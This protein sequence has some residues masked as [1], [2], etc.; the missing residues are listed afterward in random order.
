M[1]PPVVSVVCVKSVNNR[2][3]KQMRNM[4][5]SA[6]MLAS[7][8][9]VTPSLAADTAIIL[10]NTANPGGAESANGTSSATVLSSN[11]NGI[12]ISASSVQKTTVPADQLTEANLNIDN[13]TGSVET[14]KIIAGANMFPGSASEF[15]L[16]GTIGVTSG[17]ADLVGQY[18]VDNTDTLNGEA[19][20]VTGVGI[21][22]FDSGSLTGPH[23][24][25][26][27][28]TAFDSASG[29]YGL[30]EE[31]TLTLQPGA[32]I[33]VQGVSMTAVPEPRTWVLMGAG[34]GLMALL[35][36]KRK[37]Q[38]YAIS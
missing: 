36:Y 26:F 34:F 31:L 13:T 5:L 11:L 15:A 1:G 30:A 27:N 20:S 35:G 14:L 23:S 33:F 25:A 8:T 17:S 24:F 21:D 19:L 28:G 18:F 2:R 37:Q 16:T 9:L 7:L 4:L 10:W 32:A 29:P 6:T 12:T 38:R 22:S 3:D